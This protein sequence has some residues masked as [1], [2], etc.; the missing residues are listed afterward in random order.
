MTRA[1]K[2][3]DPKA[4]ELARAADTATDQWRDKVLAAGEKLGLDVRVFL[5]HH[6]GQTVISGFAVP[7]DGTELP[8]GWRILKKEKLVTPMLKEAGAPARQW[9]KDHEAPDSDVAVMVREF[10]L[11]THSE[12]ALSKDGRYWQSPAT[13]FIGE[14]AVYACF[15][16][17]KLYTPKG[18]V[19]DMEPWEEIPLWLYVKVLDEAGIKVQL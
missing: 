15:T 2:I 5:N 10:G 12:S 9:L 6:T 16:Y 14:D 8:E 3:T 11:A 17:D 13:L 18:E 1:F 19:G 4:V 7:P